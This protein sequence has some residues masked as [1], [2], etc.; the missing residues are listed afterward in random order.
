[1]DVEAWLSEAVKHFWATRGAQHARQGSATGQ[2]DAGNRAA[3]TGGKHADGFINLIA[4]IVR[5]AGLSDFAI[6][7][8]EKKTKTLPGYFRPTKQPVP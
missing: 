2:K 8:S 4:K 6:H 1:M 3:V 7:A 5:D